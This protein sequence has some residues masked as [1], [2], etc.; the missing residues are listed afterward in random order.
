MSQVEGPRS[1]GLTW[2]SVAESSSLAAIGSTVSSPASCRNSSGWPLRFD[3]LGRA[4]VRSALLLLRDVQ[5]ALWRRPHKGEAFAINR[6]ARAI[7]AESRPIG[8][9]PWFLDWLPRLWRGRSPGMMDSCR[10]HPIDSSCDRR[11]VRRRFRVTRR[12]PESEFGLRIPGTCRQCCAGSV[13]HLR[14][15][16][17]SP[18]RRRRQL[19]GTAPLPSRSLNDPRP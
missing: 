13:L 6:K 19:P 3:T 18:A 5:R 9:L 17:G 16:R 11:C 8:E 7:H 4:S 1:I 12:T 10:Y 2:T 15:Q 14:E